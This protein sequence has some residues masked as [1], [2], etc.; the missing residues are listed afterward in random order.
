MS[1]FLAGNY[2][3]PAFELFGAAHIAALLC[4]VAV[5]LFLVRFRNSSET[6][7]RSIRWTLAIVIWTAEISWHVWNLY[8]GYWSVQFMLPLNVCSVLIWLS[9]FMLILKNRPIYEF[10]YFLGIAACAN[11]L[12]TPDLGIYGFPH[13]RFIQTFISHGGV[14]TAAVYMT[15]VE[16][17]RPTWKSFGRVLLGTNVYMLA[18]YFINTA[19][20]S[21]Y[22]L[23][24]AKPTTASMLEFMPAWPYYIIDL[25]L[26]GI[27]I[28]LLLY[29]P[30]LIQDWRASRVSVAQD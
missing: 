6:T 1:Q 2:T 9:G 18:I 24:N 20:G 16:G 17:L 5:N 25:E 10:A 12:L 30:F 7:K 23:M 27:A 28:F 11:Y 13:Y 4:L 29:L 22:L 14:I 3:G 21:N 8:W 15:V 19:L 26:I